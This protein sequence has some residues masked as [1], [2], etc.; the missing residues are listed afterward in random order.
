MRT[1][2]YVDG[3]NL[4]YC[5]LKGTPYKWLNIKALVE[6]IFPRNA[7]NRIRYFTALVKPPPWDPQKPQRQQVYIR[8]LKTLPNLSVHLGQFRSHSREMPLAGSQHVH[9]QMVQ[10]LYTEEKGSDVNLATYLLLDGFRRDFDAAIVISNDS[11]LVE[12]IKV[13]RCELG[14]PMGVLCPQANTQQIARA[15]RQVAS[16]YRPVTR[17]VLRAGQFPQTLTDCHGTFHRPNTW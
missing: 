1:N 7:V 10:V 9:P 2:I 14:L 13:V 12:P 4:Y 17:S 15:L 6:Y 16:F 11:D 3:F 5:A 8:A